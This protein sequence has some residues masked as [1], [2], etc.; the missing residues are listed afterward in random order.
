MKTIEEF[1]SEVMADKALAEAAYKARAEKRLAEFLAEHEVNGTAEGFNDFVDKK[2]NASREL[3]DDELDNVSGGIDWG[4]KSGYGTVL[5]NEPFIYEFR[6][7][8]R[9]RV[10]GLI[11]DSYGTINATEEKHTTDGI[12]KKI[13]YIV[14]E[15]K[16]DN[17]SKEWIEQQYLAHCGG[18]AGIW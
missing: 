9:V 18:A 11:S 15:V 7:G 14:Y 8:E 5:E 2:K 13:K 6:I 3:S 17:G 16:Y 1:Y 10:W 12:N 4:G